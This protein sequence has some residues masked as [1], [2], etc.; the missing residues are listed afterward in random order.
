M[1]IFIVLSI[2]IIIAVIVIIMQ[3][4]H[5]VKI[6]KQSIVAFTGTLGS[7]KTYLAVKK[8]ISAYKLQALKHKIYPLISWCPL[9]VKYL[10]GWSYPATL[11]SNIPIRLKKDKVCEVLKREHLLDRNTLPEKCVVLVDELGA[12]ASQ[13]D[14]DNPLVLEQLEK[15]IRF[16]RHFVNGKMYVTDQV[17]TNIVKPIRSRLGMIY[18]LHDFRRWCSVTPFYKVTAVPLLLVEDNATNAVQSTTEFEQ[19]YL[20]GRLP[21]RKSKNKYQ[22]RC[23]KPIYRKFAVRDLLSFDETLYT[24]YLIDISVSKKVS[25]DYQN[26]KEKYKDFIYQDV[27]S[28]TRDARDDIPIVYNDTP[29]DTI[30]TVPVIEDENPT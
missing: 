18:N 23:Y 10:N 16:F 22:T 29:D 8:A 2:I 27:S 15:N 21:Y 25:K 13:W 3:F 11:Y 14:F 4:V 24:Q 17:A 19:S 26:N 1:A 20:F 28:D 6:P 5:S 30:V 12:I 7:G 9:A